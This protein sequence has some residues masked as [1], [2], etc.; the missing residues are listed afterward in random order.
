MAM[1]DYG[2]IAKKNGEVVTESF[3]TNMKDT[4]GISIEKTENGRFIDGNYFVF[5][6]DRDFYVGIYKGT[7]AIF[8]DNKQIHFIPDLYHPYWIKG[9]KYRHKEIVNGVDFDIKRIDEGN[10]YYGK[11]TY[12]GDYYEFIY[13]Y[14]VD[15][16]M[17]CWYNKSTKAMNKFK[18]FMKV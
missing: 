11:F 5:L 18:R 8:N 2:V 17:D 12:K 4:M 7:I 15:I 3:F 14:G 6:G 10:R 1:V 16:N 9:T 13:G